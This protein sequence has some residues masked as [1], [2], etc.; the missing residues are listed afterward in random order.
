M[1][2]P[3]RGYIPILGRFCPVPFATI[4]QQW[5]DG[6][7]DRFINHNGCNLIHNLICFDQL[8][9]GD[10]GSNKRSS[11]A[12]KD[13]FYWNVKLIRIGWESMK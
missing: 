11:G 9:H 1:G 10:N 7:L 12:A 4:A 6:I 13:C 5:V 2:K 8:N 3:L